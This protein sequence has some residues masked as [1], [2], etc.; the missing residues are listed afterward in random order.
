MI[1]FWTRIDNK[2]RI[3]TYISD[4]GMSIVYEAKDL[5][6]KRTV[7]FKILRKELLSDPL[8]T[9]R[10]NFEADVQSKLDNEHIVKIYDKGVYD[11]CPYI[12]S[13]YISGQTLEDKLKLHGKFSCKEASKIMLQLANTVQYIHDQGY[14]H[15]DI[16]SQNIFCLKNNFVKISDFGIAVTKDI[17]KQLRKSDAVVGSPHYLAPELSANGIISERSDVYALGVVY[18]ELVTNSY[19]YNADNPVDVAVKHINE[20]TPYPSHINK[21]VLPNLENI[22]LK[23]MEKD[24]TKRYQSAK[25]MALD[26]EKLLADDSNFKNEKKG[27]FQRLFGFKD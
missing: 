15:R 10:F 21:N 2:Y 23:A 18:F 6:H 24:P 26:I 22:I 12:V 1:K 4:G 16:K 27:F 17:A 3:N 5:I 9:V 7:A 13:E 20:P 25:E 19:P 11:S 8:N 14:I